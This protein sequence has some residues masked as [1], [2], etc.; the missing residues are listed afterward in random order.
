MNPV[1]NFTPYFLKIHFNKI[2][3]SMPKSPK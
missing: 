1:H 3:P 2:L